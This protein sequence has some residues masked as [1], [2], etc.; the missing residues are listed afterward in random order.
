M[1][2]WPLVS[3]K[4][5]KISVH[6]IFRS[7]VQI[8]VECNSITINRVGTTLVDFELSDAEEGYLYI[9]PDDIS[10]IVYTRH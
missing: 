1:K 4:K 9:R 7:G 5:Y 10:A 8:V 3:K 6:F 2:L